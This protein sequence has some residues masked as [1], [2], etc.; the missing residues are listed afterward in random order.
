MTSPV[1]LPPAVP[2]QGPRRRPGRGP[3]RFGYTSAVE[4]LAR[5]Y[6]PPPKDP[7]VEVPTL[8]GR[9]W[10][11]REVPVSGAVEVIRGSE[12]SPASR[13]SGSR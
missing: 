1:L 6:P 7:I 13:S 2:P 9:K 12:V 3:E 4:L 11:Q 10:R 8:Q 5:L